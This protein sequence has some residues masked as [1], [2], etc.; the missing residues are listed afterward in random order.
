MDN[1]PVA[2]Q[3]ESCIKQVICWHHKAHI[4]N[5]VCLSYVRMLLIVLSL[6]LW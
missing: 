2:E 1:L 6:K 4:D 5:I 3:Q